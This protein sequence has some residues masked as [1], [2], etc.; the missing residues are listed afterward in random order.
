MECPTC[1]APFDSEQG[2]RIHY[3]HTHEG[4]LPNRTCKGCGT[5]FYDPKSR[6]TFCDDCDPN[7]G[8]NN[9][10]WR[11]AKKDSEC[12]NCG[13]LFEYYPSEKDGMNCPDC[14]SDANGLLPDNPATRDRVSTA[15]TFCGVDIEARPSRVEKRERGV[16]CDLDCYGAWLSENVVGEQHHQWEGGELN[17]GESWWRIRRKALERD[18]YT[19]QNCGKTADEIGRNPDVHHVEPV[20]NFE[21]TQRAHTLDN[22]IAL[23]R[24]CHR[25]V[26]AGN[27]S[28]S[29]PSAEK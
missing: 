7:G 17:Y 8:E 12:R 20:R 10:N 4:N 13:S 15:C 9:G 21:R 22:V 27:A 11:D 2:M 3:G 29:V 6:L 24:S 14:V 18:D 28:V 25:N 26:E 19:C 16:F 1:G 23:C 5:E